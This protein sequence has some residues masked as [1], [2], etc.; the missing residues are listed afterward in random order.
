MIIP[1]FFVAMCFYYN[2]DTVE[3]DLL[4]VGT[5]RWYCRCGVSMFQQPRN[6]RVH[7]QRRGRG[8]IAMKRARREDLTPDLVLENDEWL[9]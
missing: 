2:V 8:K 1:F 5:H 4:E 6:L 3:H 9:G 7:G